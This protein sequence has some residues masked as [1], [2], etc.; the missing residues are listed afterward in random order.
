M[1][2]IGRDRCV[3]ESDFDQLPYLEAVVKE[4]LRLHPAA[5]FLL[6]YKAGNDV[7]L[8]GYTIPKG[9]RVLVNAWAIAR[10]PKNWEDPT[11]FS[12]ERF[13]NSEIDFRGR[14]FAYIPFGAGRRI[15]PG[16][17]LA[18]RMVSLL[19][20][21]LI[22]SFE[23]KLPDGIVAEKLDMQDQFGITLKKAAPLCVIPTPL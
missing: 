3:N 17:P 12:P 20:A 16:L 8:S 1:E 4:T 19:L 11:E 22:Q 6:P 5:P 15:C 23:W 18:L 2:K 21:S 14:D 7:D 10:D 13:L 9:T